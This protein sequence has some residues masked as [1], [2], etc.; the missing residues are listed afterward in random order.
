MGLLLYCACGGVYLAC[1]YWML[2]L[3]PMWCVALMLHVAVYLEYLAVFLA[4]N[5]SVY[6]VSFFKTNIWLV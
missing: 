1:G 4:Y 6:L 5:Y 2:N 3:D